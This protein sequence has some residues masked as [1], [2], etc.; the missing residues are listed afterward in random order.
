MTAQISL[1]AQIETSNSSFADFTQC[2][3]PIVEVK[4]QID[5]KEK[6]S[7]TDHY[8]FYSICFQTLKSQPQSLDNNDDSLQLP[9]RSSIPF[10]SSQRSSAFEVYRKPTPRES[11]SPSDSLLIT[12]SLDH[13]SSRLTSGLCKNDSKNLNDVMCHLKEQ[14]QLLITM[15]NDLSEELLTV[16]QKKVELKS[17]IDGEVNSGSNSMGLVISKEVNNQSTV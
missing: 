11:T 1:D 14:N 15:C 4:S 17:K 16:Q 10:Q 9:M 3:E 8:T 6:K 12:K 13:S 7:P 2:P 5:K